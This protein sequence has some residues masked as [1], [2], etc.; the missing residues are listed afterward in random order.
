MLLLVLPRPVIAANICLAS[1]YK[2]RTSIRVFFRSADQLSSTQIS[3]HSEF[4]PGLMKF[5]DKVKV[6][7]SY[8]SNR[9]RAV[10]DVDGR[11]S[12]RPNI[13]QAHIEGGNLHS[14]VG[15]TGIYVADHA[16][17]AYFNCAMRE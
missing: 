12:D 11:Y 5:E 7:K 16:V 10:Y 13:G 1:P 9:G 15:D 17:D 14:V 3:G 2:F 6:L 4:F 8:S